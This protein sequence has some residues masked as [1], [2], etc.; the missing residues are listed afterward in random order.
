MQIDFKLVKISKSK[1]V[2]TK[3]D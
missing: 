2:V 1:F 3:K